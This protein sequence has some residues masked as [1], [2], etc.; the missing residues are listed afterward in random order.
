MRRL[1]VVALLVVALGAPATAA[2]LDLLGT[3]A[4]TPKAA[5]FPNWHAGTANVWGESRTAVTSPIPNQ[6]DAPV[7][8]PPNARLRVGITLAL[9]LATYLLWP[10]AQTSAAIALA[11]YAAISALA[12][13]F[14]AY[15]HVNDRN[16]ARAFG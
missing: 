9:A 15:K 16:A 3:I 1:R 4:T 14:E 12:F 11:G 10:Q 6:F 13:A 7:E 5:L 2:G 8:V